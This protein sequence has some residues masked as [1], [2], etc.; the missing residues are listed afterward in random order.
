MLS[1]KI[2]D[3]VIERMDARLP[4][5]QECK[6]HKKC[7]CGSLTLQVNASRYLPF[8]WRVSHLD[9][10]PT[11]SSLHNILYTPRSTGNI[12]LF[13]LCYTSKKVIELFRSVR[14]LRHCICLGRYKVVH[15][16]CSTQLNRLQILITVK[17][18]LQ[19]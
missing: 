18:F 17:L 5:G 1:V 4:Y 16:N 6:V 2:F 14:Y 8:G 10:P 3:R 13:E 9:V 7:Q 19:C 11:V 12:H 15:K